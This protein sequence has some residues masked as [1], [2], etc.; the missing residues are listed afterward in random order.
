MKLKLTI[1]FAFG[2][3]ILLIMVG[4][5]SIAGLVV[6]SLNPGLPA[7]YKFYAQQGQP[8]LRRHAYV[9]N[10]DLRVT[11][12]VREDVLLLVGR[13]T[14]V[15][16]TDHHMLFNTFLIGSVACNLPK[17][18]QLPKGDQVIILSGC[19]VQ[20]GEELNGVIG[21]V[22]KNIYDFPPENPVGIASKSLLVGRMDSVPIGRVVDGNFNPVSQ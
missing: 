14:S 7:Q 22:W 18:I 11:K 6:L 16:E 5:E 13:V 1:S 10:S 8:E 4:C 17:G 20:P 9:Y 15:H 19:R 12:T 3:G 21:D 2:S